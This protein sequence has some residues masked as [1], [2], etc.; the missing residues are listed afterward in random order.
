[1]IETLDKAVAQKRMNK[2]GGKRLPFFFLI[3]Y[4][5]QS[6]VVM[7]LSEID[8]SEMQMYFPS[9]ARQGAILKPGKKFSFEA[10]PL[11]YRDYERGF[12]IVQRHLQ[13]GNSFLTN[14]TFPTPIHTNLELLEIYHQ[15]VAPY[16]LWWKDHFVVFSPETFVRIEHG[17]ISSFP[18]KGTLDATL[19]NARQRL[20]D[21]A[22]EKA[23]H[24]TIVDL[25]RNDLSMVASRV[26]VKHYRYIDTI[27]TSRGP[28]LQTSS[29]ISGKLDHNFHE[30][31]GDLIFRLLPAGSISGAPKPK[32]L[33]I[34]EEAEGYDRGF[35][36]GI[37]G[38]FDGVNLD[39][40]VAIRFVEQQPAGLV[41]KSGGGITAM[42][43][44]EEEYAELIQKVYLPI[45]NSQHAYA[46]VTPAL[47][48]H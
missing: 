46:H 8:T 39:S 16:K 34:I 7:P 12:E 9:F 41:Y 47:G 5:Q 6:S 33:D 10:F 14:L 17:I 27:K 42:S 28:L 30:Q 48:N 3:D 4:R 31:L 25:I 40:A 21:D 22:K 2:L 29:Q 38:Y 11:P 19:P 20:L 15:A 1:M 45:P 24:A 43:H 18:M 35:Y 32:T 36:T 13:A 37:F 44:P 26:R 23:E